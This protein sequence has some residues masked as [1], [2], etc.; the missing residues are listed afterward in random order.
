MMIPSSEGLVVTRAGCAHRIDIQ[1]F[2]DEILP[3]LH[4]KLDVDNVLATIRGSG[5]KGKQ[6]IT[7]DGRW[8]GL[9][10]SL[11]AGRTHIK[12]ARSKFAPFMDAIHAIAKA[13]ALHGADS[14]LQLLHNKVQGAGI[15]FTDNEVLPD[16]YLVTHELSRDDCIATL[17]DVSVAGSYTTLTYEDEEVCL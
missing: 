13:G 15:D 1:Y 6:P 9:A 11:D 7:K 2:F 4:P 8:K 5:E 12:L 10:K 17:A 16:A 14:S 3:P